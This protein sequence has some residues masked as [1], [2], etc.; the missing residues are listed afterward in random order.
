MIRS[1]SAYT[2]SFALLFFVLALLD[3]FSINLHMLS[4]SYPLSRALSSR[5]SPLSL[6]SP[7]PSPSP[8]V[9]F[10]SP[11]PR[12]PLSSLLS[13]FLATVSNFGD[14]ERVRE[15]TTKVRE[16]GGDGGRRGGEWERTGVVG[17][18]V[19]FGDSERG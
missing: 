1:G 8:S 4:L 10:L 19:L 13:T 16:L 18:S 6:L 3:T 17:G 5:L 7:S 2:V 9:L 14:W 11:L 12:S 15:G